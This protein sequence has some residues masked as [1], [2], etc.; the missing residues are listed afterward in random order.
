M[1]SQE[2]GGERDVIGGELGRI[3]GHVLRRKSRHV[4]G[5]VFR[6]LIRRRLLRRRVV[7]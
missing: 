6:A 4:L 5:R 2:S 3:V 7:G 1:A